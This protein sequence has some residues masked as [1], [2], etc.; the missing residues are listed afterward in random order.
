[1]IERVLKV[2]WVPILGAWLS[3]CALVDQFGSRVYD[4]NLNSQNAMNQETLLNI[5][6]A[7]R[8]QPLTFVAISQVTGNQS[9]ALSNGLPTVVFG[10]GQTTMQKQAVFGP[11]SLQSSVMGSYQS[12]PLVSS[13]FQNGMLSPIPLR[14]LA[15]L[16]AAHPREP[17]Y[18]AVMEGIRLNLSNVAVYYRNDPGDDLDEHHK[19]SEECPDRVAR[20]SDR[21]FFLNDRVCS[22]SKFV[23]F[24][25]VF[26]AAGLWAQ[27]EPCDAKVPGCPAAKA[28]VFSS[29]GRLCFDQTRAASALRAEHTTPW[30]GT[31]PS[32]KATDVS[33][34][35]DV[36]GIVKPEFV[37][38]SPIGIYQ[39]LGKL[40]RENTAYRIGFYTGEARRLN[41]R[42]IEISP[43]G[44]VSCFVSVAYDGN[45]YCIPQGAETTAMMLD[46]LEQ[47]KNLSTSPTDLNAAFS[48]RLIN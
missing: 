45:M 10:P 6:R 32:A 15:L 47:L 4:G 17:V 19:F 28:G 33:V 27:L 14:T 42:F 20:S 25:Q 30:C 38:R 39:Y 16:V 21:T 29:M 46:I 26:L 5:V 18:Y 34:L 40:V 11:N 41:G 36:I 8:F 43:E 9:E 3:A 24:L 37:L 1:V 7:S 23:N 2:C 35:W 48:A 13:D 44:P 31:K 12:N 22:Y